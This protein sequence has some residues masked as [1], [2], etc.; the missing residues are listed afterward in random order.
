[1]PEHKMIEE[2]KRVTDDGYELERYV[3]PGIEE[4][5]RPVPPYLIAVYAA[6][7]VWGVY[8]LIAYWRL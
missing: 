5:M 1:M 3:T 8:Y 4:A 6:L 2:E 7:A